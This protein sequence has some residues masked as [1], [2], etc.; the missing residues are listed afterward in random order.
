MERRDTMAGKIVFGILVALVLI[1]VLQNTE[2]VEVKFLV[3]TKSMSRA[4][5]LL[6]TFLIGLAAGW[7]GTRFRRKRKK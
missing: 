4:L 3:W 2:V 6:L 1:F 7:L 5:T